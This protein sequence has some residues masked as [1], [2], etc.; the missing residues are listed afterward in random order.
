MTYLIGAIIGLVGFIFFQKTKK[1]S[2]EALLEN[3]TTK[4]KTNAL[5]SSIAKND[6]TLQSEEE[7]RKAIE[8][9]T[10]NKEVPLGQKDLIDFFNKSLDK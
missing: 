6:G 5:D 10:K 2:A 7:K 8:T 4:E 1:D 9:D 3:L